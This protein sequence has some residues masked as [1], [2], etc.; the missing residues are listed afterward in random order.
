MRVKVKAKYIIAW[1]NEKFVVF[2]NGEMLYENNE[3]KEIGKTINLSYDEMIDYGNAIISPG[4]IDLNALGDIDHS[5]FYA[6]QDNLDKMIWSEKYFEMGAREAMSPEEEAFKSKYAFAQ[7]ISHGITTA[8]PI[9]C[10]YYKK[11]AETYEEMEAAVQ[12]AKEIGIRA[13]LGPSY[14]SGMHVYDNIRKAQ[15]VRY[16]E[17]EGAKGLERAK[18]FAKKYNGAANDMVRTVMVPERIELQTEEIL[19]ETKRFTKDWNLI[20]R[21]HAAQSNFE[22]DFIQNK[23]HQSPIA[24]LK[25]IGLLDEKT[26]IPHVTHASG[27]IEVEDKSDEDLKILRDAGSS[28]IH[29]PLV[30]ARTGRVLNSFGRYERNG[31]NVCMGTDTF[32]TD[33]FEI[34]RLASSMAMMINHNYKESYYKKFFEAV[35]INA[36]KALGRDDLGR[37]CKGAKADFFVLDLN[38][39]DIGVYDDPIRTMFMCAHGSDISHVIINGKTVLKDGKIVDFDYEKIQYLAQRYYDKMKDSYISRSAFPKE[40]FYQYSYEIK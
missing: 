29:C 5:L 18:E 23:Y 30:Q 26:L 33:F 17:K 19:R 14:I 27:N 13:Y 39:F 12:N 28:V 36:A 31:I 6:E 38:K 1:E 11:A 20:M 16:M 10:V 34:I 7:L 9:T 40:N 24:Y 35:T 25:S 32:P 2:E 15:T 3:I 22:Y 8:M 4:F 21:L 37:L